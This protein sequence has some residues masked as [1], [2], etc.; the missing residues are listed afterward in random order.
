MS[1]GPPTSRQAAVTAVPATAGCDAPRACTEKATAVRK[2]LH[3]LAT[4]KTLT[5]P[6]AFPQVDAEK[7]KGVSG[8]A[9]A[10]VGVVGGLVVGAGAMLLKQMGDGKKSAP[11]ETKERV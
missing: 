6:T 11:D 5:P 1:I 7:G 2:P 9:A 4:V 8:G 3:A 10:A